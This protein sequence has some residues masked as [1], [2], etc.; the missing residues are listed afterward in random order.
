V[1]LCEN[2]RVRQRI[3]SL[4][5]VAQLDKL[6]LAA[7]EFIKI[8]QRT[9]RELKAAVGDAEADDDEVEDSAMGGDAYTNRLLGMVQRLKMVKAQS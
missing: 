3:L 1:N 7:E 6:I 9:D 4:L 5:P 2:D 8:H